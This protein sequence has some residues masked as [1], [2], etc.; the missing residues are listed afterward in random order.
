MFRGLGAPVVTPLAA[1]A[2]D[3]GFKNA[4]DSAYLAICFSGLY[5]RRSRFIGIESVLVLSTLVQFPLDALDL[6]V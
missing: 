2:K 4:V 5:V 1:G 6:I 3:P